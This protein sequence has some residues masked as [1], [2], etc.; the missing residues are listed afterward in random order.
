MSAALAP[1]HQEAVEAVRQAAVKHVDET[2]WKQ[3][4]RK[5]WLWVAAT[6][7]VVAFVIDLFRNVTALRKLIGPTLSGILCRDRWRAY[8]HSPCCNV[9]CAGPTSSGTGRKCKSV[10]A[11]PR[12]LPR[13]A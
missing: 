4:G 2:G 13:L 12:S 5:R 9:R 10:A 7:T 3:A 8:D 11:S 1:A 6:S